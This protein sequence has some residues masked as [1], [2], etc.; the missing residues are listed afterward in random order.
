MNKN[1]YKIWLDNTNRG[2]HIRSILTVLTF[3]SY[4]CKIIVDL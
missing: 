1:S 3:I 4:M 2:V